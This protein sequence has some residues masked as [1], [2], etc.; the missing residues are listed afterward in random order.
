MPRTKTKTC[1]CTSNLRGS[2]PPC[3]VHVQQMCVHVDPQMYMSL[4]YYRGGLAGPI[5]YSD[6]YSMI[7]FT[8]GTLDRRLRLVYL[9]GSKR[10]K[11]KKFCPIRSRSG[12]RLVPPV[13]FVR[14][15]A[16]PSYGPGEVLGSAGP[17]PLVPEHR[18]LV[19]RRWD[20]ADVPFIPW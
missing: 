10:L 7:R 16:A 14:R 2:R 6:Y 9:P 15:I 4:F 12:L 13:L 8:T 3:K 20:A 1:T 11:R 18:R 5:Y 19:G 17:V